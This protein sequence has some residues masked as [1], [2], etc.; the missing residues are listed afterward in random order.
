MKAVI[1]KDTV[2]A[3]P[4]AIVPLYNNG[5]FGRPK[6]NGLYFRF[7]EAAYLLYKKKIEI[8]PEG[9]KKE[10]L[11]LDGFIRFAARQEDLFELK[12]IVYK[13]LKERG[14]YVQSSV[15]DFRVY[16]RGGHPGKTAAKTFVSVRSERMPILLTDLVKDLTSAQSVRKDLVLAVVDEE[17]DI[18]FYAVRQCDFVGAFEGGM[19]VPYPEEIK[20]PADA[21]FMKERVIVPDP[22]LSGKLYGEFFFGRPLD[23]RRLQLSLVEALY[24]SDEGLIRICDLN[25]KEMTRDEFIEKASHIEPE[26]VRKQAVY[27]DL[28]NRRF[29]PKTGFKFGTHFRIYQSFASPD[30]VPHSVALLHVIDKNHSFVLPPTSGAVRLSNSVRKKMIYAYEN[31]NRIDYIEFERIKM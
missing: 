10:P 20:G 26:F 13:D 6:E 28:K 2:A 22:E 1:Q 31:G 23:E 9:K 24:L 29:V 3:G 7:V 5:Y 4:E 19:D 17:S 11:D 16:P 8:Y 12:Y 27:K 14:Y 15:T 21:Y 18:T 25:G 30:K